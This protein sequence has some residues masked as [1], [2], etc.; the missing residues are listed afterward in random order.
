M[1]TAP[2]QICE[3]TMLQ[4]SCGLKGW[5]HPASLMHARNSSEVQ[6]AGH[7]ICTIVL[8]RDNFLV[9]FKRRRILPAHQKLSQTGY[10]QYSDVSYHCRASFW[11]SRVVATFQL[12]QATPAC[13]SPCSCQSQLTHSVLCAAGAVF[14]CSHFAL[15]C[16]MLAAYQG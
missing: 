16:C 3:L 11:P 2:Q 5:L 12:G 6:V 4:L 10:A 8:P 15:V 9:G 14:G 7:H 13:D 1:W